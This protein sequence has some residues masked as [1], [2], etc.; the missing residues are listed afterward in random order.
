MA[1]DSEDADGPGSPLLDLACDGMGLLD[2]TV[3]FP[4]PL[5]ISMTVF[6]TEKL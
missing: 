5:V 6:F 4:L 2:L 1:D 3:V